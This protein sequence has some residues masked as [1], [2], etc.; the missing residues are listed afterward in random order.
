MKLTV[1]HILQFCY[2]LSINDFILFVI[3][4]KADQCHAV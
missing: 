4:V 1:G 2:L 3:N